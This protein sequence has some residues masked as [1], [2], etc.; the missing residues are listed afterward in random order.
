MELYYRAAISGAIIIINDLPINN[1]MLYEK[2]FPLLKMPHLASV[3][4]VDD[5]VLNLA[6][7]LQDLSDIRTL[8]VFPGNGA[9]DFFNR[10]A[11][12]GVNFPKSLDIFASRIWQRG[13]QPVVTVNWRVIENL[14]SICRV[15]IIDDVVSSGETILQVKKSSPDLLKRLNW[16]TVCWVFKHSAQDQIKKEFVSV[17]TDILGKRINGRLAINSF[18]TLT[19]RHDVL[20]SFAQTHAKNPTEFCLMV[21]SLSKDGLN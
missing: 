14:D 11:V 17:E 10:L 16:Q 21:S 18:S 7:Q 13:H 15:V 20:E 12:L 3:V 9:K 6:E 19:K 1:S 8:F 2:I 4:N 5:C